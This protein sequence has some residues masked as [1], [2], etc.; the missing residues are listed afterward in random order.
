MCTRIFPLLSIL[1]VFNSD[2]IHQSYC[3]FYSGHRTT[4]LATQE[5]LEDFDSLLCWIIFHFSSSSWR[6]NCLVKEKQELMIYNENESK[7]AREEG[8]EEREKWLS[9]IFPL[10]SACIIHSSVILFFQI[11]LF[12]AIVFFF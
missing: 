7:R 2:W 5:S 3:Y 6:W 8:R 1:Y 10:F 4:S 9:N 12:V 11:L